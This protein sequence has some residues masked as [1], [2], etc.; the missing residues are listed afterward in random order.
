MSGPL[1]GIRVV[2][3]GVW[4]A[5]PSTAGVLADWG[6]DVVKVE[7]P[8]GDPLRGF[9]L[10]AAGLDLPVNPPFELDNRGKRSISIDI[11][12]PDGARLV[13][14][15]VSRADVFLTNVRPQV[16]ERVGLD[17]GSLAAHNSRLVYGRITGYGE[18]GP[19]RDRAAYDLGAYWSRAGIAA[20]LTA[21]GAHPP[22]QRGGFGDHTAG[23]AILG[24]ILAALL[25][26]EKTGEGQFVSTSL[27]RTGT[28]VLGFDLNTTLRLGITLPQPTRATM[29]NPLMTCYR[30]SDGRWFWLLGLQA[31]RHWPDLLRA[32]ERP[33]WQVDP[34][35][36]DIHA[37]R[38][39]SAE[40]VAL[41]DDIFSTRPL[42][43]W[44][45]RFDAAG[46]WWAPV[47]TADE[48]IADPQVRAAGAFVDV[49]L[50]DGGTTP[51]IASPVD[52]SSNRWEPRAPVPEHGQ[53][54]EEILMELGYDWEAIAD[55]KQRGIIP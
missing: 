4:V 43:E 7:P 17:Y 41:L 22:Y 33:E 48:V 53:H 28:Y 54:T 52:F 14:E 45:E 50:A 36:Q 11:A 47:Q 49:P 8:R 46:M 12:N 18:A 27:L 24:G 32:V 2:E 16:L 34:R 6:A 20:A 23:L 30:A 3:L 21:P 1:N 9:F 26:R 5:A 10:A 44:A 35:F 25:A 40:L 15:L 39:H 29:P 13:A 55:L 38:Q 37:R 19:E 31:D 42:A 51:M